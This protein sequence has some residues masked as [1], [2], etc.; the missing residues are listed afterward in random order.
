MTVSAKLVKGIDMLC[1]HDSWP[2]TARTGNKAVI[3]YV[4]ACIFTLQVFSMQ[5]NWL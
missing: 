1:T 3:K 5:L 2:R 4:L